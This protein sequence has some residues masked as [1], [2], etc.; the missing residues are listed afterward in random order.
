MS[1]DAH[2]D[3]EQ[4]EKPSSKHPDDGKPV[5]L[6]NARATAKVCFKMKFVLYV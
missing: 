5:D 1:E 4:K 2:S 6:G 3:V